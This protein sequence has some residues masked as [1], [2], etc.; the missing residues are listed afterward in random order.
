M[1]R[2]K[3]SLARAEEKTGEERRGGEQGGSWNGLLWGKEGSC[4]DFLKNIFKEKRGHLTTCAFMRAAVKSP[5]FAHS[6]L[7]LFEA[8]RVGSRE[9]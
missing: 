3:N 2:S 8:G 4:A 5:T 1:R 6:I 9:R 7:R